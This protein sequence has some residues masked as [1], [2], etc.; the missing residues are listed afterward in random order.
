LTTL[1]DFWENKPVVNSPYSNAFMGFWQHLDELKARLIRSLF[2]FF[3]GFLL[4]YFFTNTRVL[5]FLQAP[6]FQ[7]LPPEQQKLYFTSIFENFF[8]HLKIA[9]Y[10]SLFALSPFYFYQIW[11]FIAPGLEPRERKLVLPFVGAASFFFLS[12]AAFAYYVLFP[13]GFK[14]FVSFGLTTDLPLLTIDSYYGTCLKLM[15]L[16]GAAFELPVLLILLGMLGV[17]S[18]ESLRAQRRTA[19]MAITIVSAFIAPP[20]AVS[21]LLLMAPLTLMYEG[22]TLVVALIE[23]RR[24]PTE[25][26]EAPLTPEYD[27]FVGKSGTT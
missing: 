16:F 2:V 20:D 21:M 15:F 8:T 19:F 23:K 5:A 11:A 24:A 17:V 1:L 4:A 18:A 13:I 9:G 14:F 7:A 25:A 3:A 27:P 22:A 6:L 12:G 10:T 26:S